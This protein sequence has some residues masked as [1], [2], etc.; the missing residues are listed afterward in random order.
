MDNI[1]YIGPY[2]EFSG[3]GNAARNYIKSLVVAGYNVSIRPIYNVFQS[4]PDK[5]LESEILD[6]EYNFSKKYHKVIQHCYPH[7]F[8]LNKK[9]DQH[10]GIVHLESKNYMKSLSPFI[11]LMDSIIVGSEFVKNVLS[12]DQ[13]RS[14]KIHVVPEPININQIHEYKQQHKSQPKE[15]DRYSFYVISDFITRK[16]I[17]TILLAFL[18]LSDKFE[19]IDLI[20]KTKGSGSLDV[21]N[22]QVIQYEFEKI[23]NTM[24]KNQFRKPRILVGNT[25]YEAIKYIHNNNDCIINISSGESFGY[26][27]LEAMCFN[28][29]TIVTNNTALSEL[30]NNTGYVVDSELIQCMDSDRIFHIYNSIDQKWYEPSL[31]SLVLQMSRAAHESPKNKQNRI[32]AQNNIVT[33]M[34][35]EKT[36]E[37]LSTI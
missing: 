14:A 23:Y 25:K 15:S 30:T 11:D 9:F 13:N 5:E 3:M 21:V 12:E 33:N 17:N 10:I 35:I 1:L 24:R 2:R 29:N 31:D 18:I 36:A 26:S 28:N 20:I 8:C 27:V 19:Y 34:T 16:N 32:E 22:D 37:K 6:L 7:Q 4:Y